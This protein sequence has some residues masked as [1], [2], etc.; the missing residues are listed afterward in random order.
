MQKRTSAHTLLIIRKHAV[1]AKPKELSLRPPPQIGRATRNFHSDRHARLIKRI[2][3]IM[4]TLDFFFSFF[5]PFGFTPPL[6]NGSL[7]TQEGSEM[8]SKSKTNYFF[9]MVYGLYS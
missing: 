9:A 2:M 8:K 6:K 1:D 3:Y 7:K 5:A 4:C